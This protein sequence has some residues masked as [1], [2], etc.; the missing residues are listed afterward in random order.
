MKKFLLFILACTL[1]VAIQ[2]CWLALPG[3]ASTSTLTGV[4]R[5]AQG[6]PIQGKLVM[7]LP[8][9]A[10]DTATNTLVSSAPVYFRLVNGAITGGAPLYDVNGLQPS[11]LY[12]RMRAYD[13]AGNMVLAG[14]YVVTGGSFNLS[15]AV[16]TSVTTSNISYLNPIS[17]SV[18]NIFTV[19]QSFSR[20]ISSSAN[21]AATGFIGMESGDFLGW[22]NNANSADVALAKDTSDALNWNGHVL[23]S[24]A[25]NVPVTAL[26]AGTG[27]TS[28]TFWRGDGTWS[29]TAAGAQAWASGFFPGA[30]TNVTGPVGPVY[31]V[32]DKA[33]TVTRFTGT[34]A[35]AGA[36]C[37]TQATF[38]VQTAAS[39]GGATSNIAVAGTTVNGQNWFDSGVVSVNVAAGLVLTVNRTV[40]AAGCGTAPTDSNVCVRFIYQ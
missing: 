20:I 17:T 15:A 10:V 21:P 26:N 19:P 18:T 40:A 24:S 11:G 2:F 34:V 38:T 4:L 3:H 32:L 39:L 6:N 30:A 7:N 9:P 22:R 36:T 5:D 28:S 37:A 27:A 29:S 33:I 14:N 8:V 25:G 12:Y 31:I 13:T 16:P 35:T 1:G 23:I